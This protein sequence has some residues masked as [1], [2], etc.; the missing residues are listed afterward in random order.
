MQASALLIIWAVSVLAISD[1]TKLAYETKSKP[2]I[3]INA[4]SKLEN[5]KKKKTK[6][7]E[8]VT[9]VNDIIKAL[10][11]DLKLKN[12]TQNKWAELHGLSKKN[13][14]LIRNHEKRKNENKETA[15]PAFIKRIAA[16]LGINQNNQAELMAGN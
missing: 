16:E 5:N 14:S 6:Q 12:L 11:A 2:L 10:D 3:K 7:S 4:V 1:L 13:V 15:S 9:N 8:I